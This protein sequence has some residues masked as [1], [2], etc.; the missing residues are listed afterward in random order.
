MSEPKILIYDIENSPETGYYWPPGYDVNIIQK[1]DDWYM[2]SFA[3][4]WYGEPNSKI[5]YVQKSSRRGDDKAL[6]KELWQLYDEADAVMAHNGDQFDQK[7]SWTRMSYHDLGPCSSYLEIDTLKLLRQKFKH[8]SN[9]LDIVA[10]YYGIG[11]KLP[12]GGF[13]TWL[14]CMAGDVKSWK[15]MEKYNKHDVVLLDGLYERI[16]PYVKTRVNFQNWTGL[17]TCPK[18]GSDQ[19]R[20][21]GFRYTAAAKKQA[22]K[23]G[24]CGSRTVA[25]M[26][27]DGRLRQ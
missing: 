9:K 7:K 11:K 21:N 10:Q 19:V 27:D 25:L 20:P 12:T 17:G 4:K 5:K 14:G 23:C 8:S 18:C 3:Y 26:A 16:K 1:I 2:L 24:V 15:V 6:C 22:Y 13:D